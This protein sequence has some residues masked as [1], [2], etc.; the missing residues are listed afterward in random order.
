MVI[1]NQRLSHL[2][3]TWLVSLPVPSQS[4]EMN[5]PPPDGMATSRPRA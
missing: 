2:S 1:G 4:P 5:R 3:I